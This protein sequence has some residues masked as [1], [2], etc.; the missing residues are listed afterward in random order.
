M[1]R[2]LPPAL[3]FSL[4]EILTLLLVGGVGFAALRTGGMMASATLVVAA[5]LFMALAILA[6][7]GGGALRAGAIGFVV[8]GGIYGG[9]V[10]YF[11]A[12]ELGQNGSLPT[13]QAL[14]PL[15]DAMATFTYT[16]VMTGKRMN[17][18]KASALIEAADAA[19]VPRPLFS[20]ESVPTREEFMSVAHALIGMALGYAGAK[21]AVA[22]RRRE[23]TVEEAPPT[24]E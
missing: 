12:A 17:Q 6:I 3:K 4:V 21:F 13:S 11:G 20:V 16:D 18:E 7:V 10:F 19:S 23:R 22:V 14:E 24:G 15:H 8:A 5:L 9:L 1:M 2:R